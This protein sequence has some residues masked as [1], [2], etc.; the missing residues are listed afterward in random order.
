MLEI[1]LIASKQ[2]VTK[3]VGTADIPQGVSEIGAPKLWKQ[4]IT[5]KNIKIAILDTGCDK[6]HP[7][8]AGQIIGGRNFTADDKGD[9]NNYM[10]Y[11]GHGTHVAGT[12][13]AKRDGS[14]V[15]GVAPDAKLLILKV[16][17]SKG[18][19][20]YQGLIAA[21]DY[22]I[23]QKVS[24]ISM[25]LGGPQDYPPLHNIIK[26]AVQAEI[27]VVCAASNDGDGRPETSEYAYPAYY[28]EVVSVGAMT[29]N[30]QGAAFS[31]SNNQVDLIAPGVN[32]L[33]T[34]PAG[35]YVILSGTSM[36][37][38][39]VS[40]ALALLAEWGIKAFGR[41][42]TELE[43]YAQL[44]KR[45]VSVKLPKVVEGNGM[46]YLPAQEELEALFQK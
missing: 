1:K 33:S 45:T 2:I 35:K 17:D 30:R 19:G 11:N 10:D 31:N 34:F 23:K 15:T 7:D 14:G 46:L 16:L 27:I 39:H 44:I 32:I 25:S 21:I 37:T 3:E 5:G 20:S 12:I 8:L 42:L 29:F 43:L 28:A 6:N 26:K 24:I 22:A 38:P 9:P 4:D 13:A 40:G 18:T 36:A 41:P